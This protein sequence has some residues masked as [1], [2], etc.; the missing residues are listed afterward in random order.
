MDDPHYAHPY[1]GGQLT[2]DFA[3]YA[4][5]ESPSSLHSSFSQDSTVFMSAPLPPKP[6]PR[7]RNLSLGKTGFPA[8][9][10]KQWPP[11]GFKAPTLQTADPMDELS[12]SMSPETDWLSPASR[13]SNM[14][15]YTSPTGR[16]GGRS[17]EGGARQWQ[18]S[19]KTSPRGEKMSPRGEKMS[20]R[21]YKLQMQAAE[22]E[23]F[24]DEAR[25]NPLARVN[26]GYVLDSDQEVHAKWQR[27]QQE[28]QRKKLQAAEA[29]RQRREEG[30][31]GQVSRAEFRRYAR[32]AE[33]TWYNQ[34]MEVSMQHSTKWSWCFLASVLDESADWD[35][36]TVPLY[37]FLGILWFLDLFAGA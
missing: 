23:R 21:T 28:E 36:R 34:G 27:Y 11:Q 3:T 7:H 1:L 20:P 37:M 15:E 8:A 16:W 6:S 5:P 26:E 13:S 9:P 19:P 12:D 4:L 30:T 35:P 25:G 10:Q 24:E 22:Q 33:R 14:D 17:A 29:G 31:D 2:D 18:G 32:P